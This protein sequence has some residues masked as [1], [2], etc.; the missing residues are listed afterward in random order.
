MADPA[1]NMNPDNIANKIQIAGQV[2]Q[3]AVEGLA[4]K[5]EQTKIPKLFSEKN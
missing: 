1:N 4:T 5:T 2:V 3:A